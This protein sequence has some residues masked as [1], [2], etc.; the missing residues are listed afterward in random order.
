MGKGGKG[1]EK[2]GGRVEG[3]EAVEGHKEGRRG[4]APTKI[5]KT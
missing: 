1:A 5:Q 2:R 4:D 3:R